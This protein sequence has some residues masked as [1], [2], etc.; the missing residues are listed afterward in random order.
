MYHRMHMNN[1]EKNTYVREHLLKALLKRMEQ[2]GL[3]GISVSELAQR[4]GVGRASFY[5]NFT[6][7]EDILV[8]EERRLFEAWKENDKKRTDPSRDAFVESLLN[9]YKSNQTFYLSL[10]RVGL[11]AIVRETILSAIPIE[12][13]DPNPVA[14]VKS[15][16][17]YMIYGWVDEW[18]KR[19][20]QESG[21][22]LV[23]MMR[24][25]QQE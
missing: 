4:A 24:S 7:I 23:R 9:F 11:S 21:T 3:S 20:M 25:A 22:E 6:S 10:Y 1:Q 17:A 16:I 5:R 15:S 18:M 19:G 2:T 8:Q 12:P 14:Y 13:A